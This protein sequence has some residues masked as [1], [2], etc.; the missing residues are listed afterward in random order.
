MI[1]STRR[2]LLQVIAEISEFVPEVRLGQLVANLCMLADSPYNGS[3]WDTEDEEM[4][5]AARKH[6]ERWRARQNAPTPAAV[7]VD[8][9]TASLPQV[10]SA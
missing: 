10:P 3:V 1:T 7:D 2:E 5:A 9:H 6:L 4:L 8:I